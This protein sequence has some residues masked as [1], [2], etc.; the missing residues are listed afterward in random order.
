MKGL[1]TIL[2]S[3]K[4]FYKMNISID[5]ANSGFHVGTTEKLVNMLPE[6]GD[7]PMAGM[8]TVRKGGKA[9]CTHSML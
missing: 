9:P 4:G 2:Q 1:S 8:S 7:L 5:F 3:K 6:E